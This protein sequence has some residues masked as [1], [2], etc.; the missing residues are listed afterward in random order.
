MLLSTG[1]H[2][3]VQVAEWPNGTEA[4]TAFSFRFCLTMLHRTL[5]RDWP[6]R[7][8]KYVGTAP[9]GTTSASFFFVLLSSCILILQTWM[10]KRRCLVDIVLIDIDLTGW[11]WIP[12]PQETSARFAR[13]LQL[14]R[15]LVLQLFCWT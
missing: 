15:Q 14:I 7:S 8:S 11:C 12:T 4:L 9:S 1:H 2:P 3:R 5:A 13:E 10:C 6:S